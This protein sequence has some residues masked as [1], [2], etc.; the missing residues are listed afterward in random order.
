MDCTHAKHTVK[1]SEQTIDHEAM[2]INRLT[3]DHFGFSKLETIED[4]VDHIGVY[5]GLMFY[6][7]YAPGSRT[8]HR[9]QQD[10][11]IAEGFWKS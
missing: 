4:K 8:L 10:N 2:P 7:E 1:K 6:L 9:W 5:Q 11:K 3:R